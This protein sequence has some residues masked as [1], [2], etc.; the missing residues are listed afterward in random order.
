MGFGKPILKK[1]YGETEYRLC[2]IPLG[3]YVKMA[4]DE[5]TERLE[6]KPHEFLSRSVGDRFKII[7]AGPALNY[8]LAFLIFSVIFMF[9]SPTL[10]TEVGGFLKDYPDSELSPDVIYWLGDYYSS[11]GK[12]DKAE[13]YYSLILK[14]ISRGP[15]E[16]T[17]LVVSISTFTFL[18]SAFIF[19]DISNIF[20]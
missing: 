19:F 1:K 11:K 9:G 17:L 3:G 5:P 16:Y 18:L 13:E 15:I 6:G 8:I 10:T 14:S 12:F 20:E 4:G 2:M 7:F